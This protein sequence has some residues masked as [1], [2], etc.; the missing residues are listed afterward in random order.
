MDVGI[1]PHP[2]I[3]NELFKPAFRSILTF[4]GICRLN[5]GRLKKNEQ[6]NVIMND[7]MTIFVK[8]YISIC[9]TEQPGSSLST[10]IPVSCFHSKTENNNSV[11]G[12]HTILFYPHTFVHTSRLIARNVEVGLVWSDTTTDANLHTTT[13]RVEIDMED[14]NISSCVHQRS[15]VVHWA[16]AEMRL[17]NKIEFGL[18]GFTSSS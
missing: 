7:W 5:V 1:S 8:Y 18:R 15:N 11:A 3:F 14:G 10:W 16:G 6:W 2:L 4:L 9:Q 17:M 12:T 13:K